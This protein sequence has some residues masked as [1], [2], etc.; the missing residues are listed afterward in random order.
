MGALLPLVIQILFITS[1]FS[2]MLSTAHT[3]PALAQEPDGTRFMAPYAGAEPDPHDPLLNAPE[4]PEGMVWTQFPYDSAFLSDTSWFDSTGR[5]LLIQRR[6]FMIPS[7]VEQINEIMALAEVFPSRRLEILFEAAVRGKA[8]VISALLDHDAKAH[9]VEGTD[10]D[11]TLVPLHAAAFH[12]HITC[13]KV[14][15]EKGKLDPDVLD[16]TGTPLQRAVMAGH[17]EVVRYLLQTG[18]VN[19][20][21]KFVSGGRERHPLE[22]FARAKTI[23]I[24]DIL[25]DALTVANKHEQKEEE[26]PMSAVP[27]EAIYAA[28]TDGHEDILKRLLELWKIRQDSEAMLGKDVL[29]KALR[30]TVAAARIGTMKVLLELLGVE[31]EM[32]GA[33]SLRTEAGESFKQ[34]ILT[35]IE[36]GDRLAFDELSSYV[37]P[38]TEDSEKDEA[39]LLQLC[40]QRAINV[41]S[42]SMVRHVMTRYEIDVN[43]GSLNP[44]KM[45]PI[46][47]ASA[48]G[49]TEIVDYLLNEHPANVDLSL[50]TDPG[51]LTPLWYAVKER[52]AKIVKLLLE[53]GAPVILVPQQEAFPDQKDLD[54]IL[55]DSF[56]PR[57]AAC[58]D[59]D[60]SIKIYV[61]R[62]AWE[63][64]PRS[65]IKSWLILSDE[66]QGAVRRAVVQV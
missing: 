62:P 1:S 54:G 34:G 66:L 35:T 61:T 11:P 37:L 57:I 4:L 60:R 27:A 17:V 19:V 39:N 21:R 22:W 40:L 38:A 36:R 56:T 3:Q 43:N 15:V 58:L 26:D 44:F 51:N 25:V 13:V 49:N 33:V 24:F 5:S 2:I 23:E 52:H 10:D 64:A 53:H 45:S 18:R 16:E 9:P 63:E 14:L 65:E 32:G 41:D 7:Q 46:A 50:G 59:V 8:H 30:L 20:G 6:V 31:S 55:E 29:E 47:M 42:L 28:S 48:R 12:G